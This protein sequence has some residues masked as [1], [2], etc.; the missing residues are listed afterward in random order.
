M[1]IRNSKNHRPQIVRFIRGSVAVLVEVRALIAEIT[2]TA[3]ALYG[4]YSAFH[5]LVR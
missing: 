5:L 4:C 3:V 1:K 2:F